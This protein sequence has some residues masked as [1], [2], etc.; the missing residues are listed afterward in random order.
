MLLLVVSC[1]CDNSRVKHRILVLGKPVICL[2]LSG[3]FV[4]YEIIM[5]NFRIIFTDH[6]NCNNN[7][8]NEIMHV[9]KLTLLMFR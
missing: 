8:N 9:N 1:D 5:I 4:M 2:L 7:F 6:S 3:M